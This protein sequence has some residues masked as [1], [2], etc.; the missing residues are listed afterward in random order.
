MLT[1]C[2][3]IDFMSNLWNILENKH[4]NH[5]CKDGSSWVL[6]LTSFEYGL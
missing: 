2:V 4:G 5:A 3:L 1:F 6:L